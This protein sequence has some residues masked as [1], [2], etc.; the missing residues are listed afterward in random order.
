MPNFKRGLAIIWL[1]FASATV[2]L[3]PLFAGKYTT[4]IYIGLAVI[5]GEILTIAALFYLFD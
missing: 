4:G 3:A 2:L 1:G 5:V